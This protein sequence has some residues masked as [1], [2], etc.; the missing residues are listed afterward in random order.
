MQGGK[1]GEKRGERGEK[2]K[3]ITVAKKK[4]F[5]CKPTV[6]SIGLNLACPTDIILYSK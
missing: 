5:I 6:R 3:N 1:N 2:V 4:K